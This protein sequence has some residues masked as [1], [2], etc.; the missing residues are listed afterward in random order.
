MQGQ[1][2]ALPEDTLPNSLGEGVLCSIFTIYTPVPAYTF[3]PNS[4]G[5][6]A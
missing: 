4:Y 6:L 1:Q 2:A 5:V 3:H